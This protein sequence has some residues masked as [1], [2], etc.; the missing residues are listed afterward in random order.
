MIA[1]LYRCEQQ[2]HYQWKP[3][4]TPYWVR[5]GIDLYAYV[6]AA[7]QQ[8]LQEHNAAVSKAKARIH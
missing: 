8:E 3:L 7:K 4:D 5:Q 2:G 6:L 1:Y